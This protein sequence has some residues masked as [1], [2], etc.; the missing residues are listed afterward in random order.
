M[1]VETR[2]RQGDMGEASP[3]IQEGGITG[4]KPCHGNRKEDID[5]GDTTEEANSSTGLT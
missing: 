1:E 5:S 2:L 4:P 3:V